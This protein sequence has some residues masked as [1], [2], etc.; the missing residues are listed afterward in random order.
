MK[1]C[2]TV[3]NDNNVT[4]VSFLGY[5]CAFIYRKYLYSKDAH[6]QHLF[7]IITGF[8]LGYWNYHNEIFHCIT[9]IIVTYAVLSVFAG[10]VVS[11]IVTFIYNLGYLLVGK[12][13]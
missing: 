2:K 9:A 1:I 4:Y 6:I 11:V 8:F 3:Q 7:F 13:S 10:S 5:P 12:F